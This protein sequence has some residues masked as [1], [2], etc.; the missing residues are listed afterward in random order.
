MF[1][2]RCGRGGGG[3]GGRE[4]ADSGK[5]L[6]SGVLASGGF[7]TGGFWDFQTVGGFWRVQ[8]LFQLQ[9]EKCPEIPHRLL[10]L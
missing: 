10:P 5:F 4:G 9:K 3:G 1:L 7:W 8:A 2:E 6:A